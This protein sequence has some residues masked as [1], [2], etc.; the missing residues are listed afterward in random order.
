[1]KLIIVHYHLR[2]GGIRRVIE[3]GAPQIV[4]H[5]GL[6][7]SE[8]VLA[9][10]E[11]ADPAWH[12]NFERLLGP[13]PVRTVVEPSF[14]YFAEQRGAPAGLR[15]RVRAACAR[16]LARLAPEEAV[17]WAHNLGIARNLLLSDELARTC[18]ERGLTLV[19]HHHDWWFD[20]RWIR[21]PEMR[22]C[23]AKNIAAAARVVFP[24]DPSVR[25]VAING[26]DARLLGDHF[27]R[28]T[29]WM[30]NLTDRGDEPPRG[31]VQAARRWLDTQLNLR[32]AP[33]WIVPCRLLRRKNV[34]EA[35]LLTRWLR[36][37]ATLVTTGA[38]SSG[39]ELPYFERI[40]DAARRHRWPLRMGVLAGGGEARKPSVPELLRASEVVLLT[41]V[42]EGFGLPFIEAAAAGRPLIARRLPIIA[43][44]LDRFGFRFP[45]LYDDVLVAPSL[46]DWEAERVRQRKAFATWRRA[47]P[48]AARRLAATPLVLDAAG[49][50]AVPF[51]RLTLTAQLEVLSLPAEES[52]AQCIKLNPWLKG[53][54]LRS[55]AERLA[56]LQW[57]RGADAWLGGRAYAERFR[58][59]VARRVRGA[60]EQGAA[61][62]AQEDFFRARL[63]AANLFPLL[64]S[65][66]S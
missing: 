60:P 10:G 17:V 3:Q 62:A 20:N 43:P 63:D 59:V 55:A 57:P 5:S 7:V 46:F 27:P 54:K 37:E 42:Q 38:A 15:R 53:W 32:G 26:E 64:W 16:L 35:L 11:L 56:P 24:A 47:L 4:A 6:P 33:V 14:G 12:G 21:W 9:T 40:R 25:H 44:D 29:G 30:P 36:P 1:L 58:A 49:P 2:P 66:D 52:W 23:G 22:R 65:R 39:D 45:N 51:S 50:C 31:R 61:V 34:A 19:S 41:S 13:T 28:T 48:A 18:A 8:V